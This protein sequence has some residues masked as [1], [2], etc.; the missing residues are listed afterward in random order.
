[1]NLEQ[2]CVIQATQIVEMRAALVSWI[3]ATDGGSPAEEYAA[4]A[5]RAAVAMDVRSAE[6]IAAARK[7][8]IE[9]VWRAITL[10]EA[11]QAIVELRK[12][13]KELASDAEKPHNAV[14]CSGCR[15]WIDPDMC[16]CGDYI[17]GHGNPD[18]T[19]HQP[20]PMGCACFRLNVS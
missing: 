8:A 7:E 17:K 9:K 15:N 6:K 19:G 11:H 4:I 18:Q 2:E 13:E 3:K 12:L 1:M 10:L 20:V 14:Q 5:A 16:G